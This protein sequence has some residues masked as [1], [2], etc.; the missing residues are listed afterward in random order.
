MQLL[1]TSEYEL[2]LI[3]VGGSPVGVIAIGGAP[4]GVIAIGI[5]PM[6]L[7][8]FAC[9]LGV[10]IGC[11]SCGIGLGSF[12]RAVGVAV[13]ADAG[14]T[15]LPITLGGSERSSWYWTC[16]ALVTAAVSMLLFHISQERI[17]IAG[18]SRV[19]EVTW[20][21]RPTKSEGIY[22]EPQTECRIHGLLRSDGI[23]RLHVRL[24]VSCGSLE[25]V[26]RHIRSGCAVQQVAVEGGHAYR[27][28]C[29]RDRVAASE[30]DDEVTPEQP[31]L[32]F[33]TLESPG[34]ARVYAH[35]PPPMNIELEVSSPSEVIDSDPLLLPGARIEAPA[36]GQ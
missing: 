13:G 31:G 32:V 9:G 23:E 5:L 12:V 34:R 36:G 18:M 6:G 27:L 26:E 24:R 25:L 10:G 4:V 3:A 33:D 15:G 16:M 29:A 17:A 14:A 35:G 22:T 11:F 1:S 30:D 21:A 8:S 2:G 7:L 19:V 20:S 28:A